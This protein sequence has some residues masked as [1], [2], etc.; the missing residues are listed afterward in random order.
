MWKG[1]LASAIVLIC[2]AVIAVSYV[3][4]R[5]RIREQPTQSGKRVCVETPFGSVGV[6]ARDNLV[7]DIGNIPIYPG[8]ERDKQD[9]GGAVV[10]IDWGSG[11]RKLSVAAAKYSTS[12]SVRQVREWYRARLLD[13]SVSDKEMIH[14]EGGLKRVISI[15]SHD[16]RTRIGIATIGE[17]VAN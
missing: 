9:S 17:P 7:P 2:L 10:D 6:D 15:K 12:D 4:P 16:G 8:A 11:E 14:I 3:V 13:W 1:L 5:I